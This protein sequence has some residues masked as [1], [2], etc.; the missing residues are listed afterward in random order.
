[1]PVRAAFVSGEGSMYSLCCMQQGKANLEAE[2][3]KMPSI[4]TI[5][6]K[7]VGK[8]ASISAKALASINHDATGTS[9]LIKCIVWWSG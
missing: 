1:M 8:I 4:T 7:L 5:F 9:L 6:G 2:K 3:W